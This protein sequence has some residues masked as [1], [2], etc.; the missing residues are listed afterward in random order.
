MPHPIVWVSFPTGVD[1]I[2]RLNEQANIADYLD[3]YPSFF[4]GRGQR[5]I[6]E[7]EQQLV[8]QA[9]LVFATADLLYDKCQVLNA[10]TQRLP[11]GVD[12]AHFARARQN[13][14]EPAEVRE[15]S[16]PR[17]GYVGTISHWTDVDT[18]VSLAQAAPQGNV[19]VIGPWEIPQPTVLPA[20]FRILGPRPYDRLPE[21]LGSLD[22][23]LIPFKLGPLTQAVNPVKL[24]EYAAAGL[25]IVATKT[26]ELERY[27]EWC[28]LADSS[29]AF[30]S[31]ALHQA[32]TND[33]PD[34]IERASRAARENDWQARIDTIN[35]FLQRL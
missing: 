16:H 23:A 22:V 10:N 8:T 31:A 33:N 30:I 7:M 35:Q 21:Y 25:P 1:L 15:L 13:L 9:D 19:I 3:D 32:T 28:S 2:G 34:Q 27:A 26:H 20:N 29:D 4:N 24:F 11:N 18:L 14:P 5:T 17:F 6:T 12:V